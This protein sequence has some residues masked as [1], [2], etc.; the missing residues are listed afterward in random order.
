MVPVRIVYGEMELGK[1]A[2]SAGGR[3]DADVTLWYIR[4]G[5][6]RETELEKHILLDAAL[7]QK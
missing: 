3:W 4:F 5:N 2:R 6:I 1:M 7:K